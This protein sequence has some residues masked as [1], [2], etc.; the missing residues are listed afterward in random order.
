MNTTITFLCEHCRRLQN[1]PMDE[2]GNVECV[3]CTHTVNADVYLGFGGV[4]AVR[5]GEDWEY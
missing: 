3:F 2:D 5:K 4:E 1:T